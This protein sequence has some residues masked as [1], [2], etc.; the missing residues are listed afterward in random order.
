MKNLL[1]LLAD[2][3]NGI[4]AVLLASM[5]T[6]VDPLW[7]HF[8]I[9]MVLA[10]SPDIDAL[11]EL[12]ARGKVASSAEHM[13]DHRTFLHYPIIS[14]PL[15]LL[16]WYCFGYWGLLWLIALCLH[17]VNDL[18]G[19]GWGVALLYP[20]SQNR[21]KI[22]PHHIFGS[23]QSATEEVFNTYT[24]EV[25]EVHIR[26]EGNENWVSDTYCTVNWISVT[27]YSLFALAVIL[28]LITLL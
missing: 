12:V 20:W 5:L 24:P 6:G 8:V 11:P 13:R 9:G 28:M 10:M 23:K 4:F 27:E 14:V 21:Y 3:A 17:L 19:T 7:W 15:G 26:E 18:Y 16:A 25:L 1:A 2:W 22:E